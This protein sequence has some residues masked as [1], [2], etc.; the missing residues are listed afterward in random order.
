MPISDNIKE[1]RALYRLSQAELGKIAGVTDKAVSTW[2]SGE[3]I[4]RMGAIQKIADY[5]GISKSDIIEDKPR[6]SS[7]VSNQNADIIKKIVETLSE[8]SE[9]AAKDVLK[10]VNILAESGLYDKSPSEEAKKAN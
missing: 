8:M 2:E 5:F 9:E 7:K 4:P 6:K 1:L 3:K 10:Y